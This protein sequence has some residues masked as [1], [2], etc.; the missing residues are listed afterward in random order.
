MKKNTLNN[1]NIICFAGEDWWYHNP[2]SNLHIMQSFAKNNRVLF[3]N[4]IGV[5]MPSLKKDPYAWKRIFRKLGSLLRYFRKGQENIYVLTP[6]AIPFLQRWRKEI[7]TV[8][9]FLLVLQ[10]RFICFFL[11]LKQPILWVCT[12]TFMDAAVALRKKFAKCLVY[13][14]VDNIA[15]FRGGDRS[16]IETLDRRLHEKSDIAFFVN[17][18]LWS[19]RKGVNEHTYYLS[20]GVDYEHFAKAQD[21][22]LP[23]PDDIKT[24]P[25]PIVGYMGIIKAI[26][27]ELVAYLGKRNPEKSF[28]FVG[29]VFRGVN[30]LTSLSNVHF[31]GQKAYS[32]LPQYLKAFDCCTLYYKTDNKFDNYRNP[33]K[34]ME[35]MA[36][37][38][39]IVTVN[40]HEMKLFKDCIYIADSYESF[41]NLINEAVEKDDF[42]R[43]DRRIEIARDRTWDTVSREAAACIAMFIE[44]GRSQS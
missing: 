25:H 8:N 20:H 9:K 2:H 37:G 27:I 41:H 42:V 4:S 14:C 13:Y 44:N 43:K 22:S 30:E 16:Y 36:T 21:D 32:V 28:V 15:Y 31:L 10:L 6:I 23:V 7:Q 33:K 12:P 38:K 5:R 26:D 29:E 3:V 24:I 35:Y 18:D 40:T 1:E 39:P 11:R 17:K 34:F 19:E